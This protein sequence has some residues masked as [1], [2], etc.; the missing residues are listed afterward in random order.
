MDD[1]S[2][3][4]ATPIGSLEAEIARLNKVIAALI[5]RAESHASFE[6]SEYGLFETA[7][8]LEAQVRRRT[9]ELE[10]ALRENERL[11]RDLHQ[12]QEELRQ[13]NLGLT[14]LSSTDALTGLA[15]RRACTDFLDV[16]WQR[17]I[18]I[19]GSIGAAMV[20]VDWFK[21]YNDQ[22]G[23]PAG[24]GCL[25][26]VATALRSHV[27]QGVDLVARYGGEEFVIV[28]PGADAVATR[29]LAERARSAV[30]D[31][32]IP[33]EG[34]PRGYVTVSVG[35]TALRPSGE[36]SADGLISRADAALYEAKR[37]GRD[38]IEMDPPE[39][40]IERRT[41]EPREEGPEPR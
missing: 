13:T 28:L 32:R 38:R 37:L 40:G 41:R 17:A 5:R 35:A 1:P 8:V 36:G 6:S 39:A 33:L 24:D 31:L 20:D 25:Q 34:T 14:V 12:A 21:R 30:A 2:P 7:V 26:D 4:A 29:F 19:G 22:Y 16:A 11:N 18:R 23:H 10:S 9:E 3:A 27:R 15:N